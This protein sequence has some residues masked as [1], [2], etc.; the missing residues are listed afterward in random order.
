MKDFNLEEELKNL[1]TGPGVYLHHNSDGEII[2]I[3]KAKNLKN[4]VSQYFQTSR[5]RS[6]KIQMMVSHI[7]YF[8]YILTE[9][10]NDA[11]LLENRLIK[12]YMPKYN[13]M[14][15]DGKTYPYIKLTT[16]ED[17][18]RL[19]KT[20]TVKK[21]KNKYYGPYP[22]ADA[23]NEIIELLNNVY[24]LR[25]CQKKLPEDIGKKRA[26]LNYHIGKCD[27]P[28]ENRITCD[29][30]AE[31]ISQVKKYL[32]GD[33]AEIIRYLKS[34]MLAASDKMEYEKAGEYKNLLQAATRIK[35]ELSKRKDWKVLEQN[36]EK[37]RAE[38]KQT[39]GAAEELSSLLGIDYAVRMES[40]DISNTSG[41]ESVASMVVYENGRPKKSDYRK[42]KIKTVKGPDDYASMAE[43]LERRFT[44]NRKNE[45]SDSSFSN[46]PDLLLI[47]GGKGQV[48]AVLEVIEK[49]SKDG[50]TELLGIPVC[51]MVKDNRHRTRGL[52]YNDREYIM[53]KN[54][55]SFKLLTRIQDETHRFAIEYHRSLRSKV[56]TKSVLDG[57]EGIG[58]KRRM[59][60]IRHFKSLDNLKAATIEEI[61]EV[62]GMNRPAAEHIKEFFELKL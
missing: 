6:V 46:L 21:D 39:K 9:T 5:E 14:L 40:F 2:Y 37:I 4:R 19:F 10:E 32:D 34:E 26:C 41:T 36:E 47:D 17:F 8:E 22:H 38:E 51:G 48:H 57:I 25:T 7:A 20:R 61:L 33:S 53:E 58:P 56:Q 62:P 3:G 59:A 31:K 13:T 30:Y 11:L 23:V 54:S 50:M 49:L 24:K 12:K 44:H 43:V 55:E 60:L 45:C 42:F 28:C 27:A 35:S 1:P 52:F 16:E 15:K 29:S 18:P